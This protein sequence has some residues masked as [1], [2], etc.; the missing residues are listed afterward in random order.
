MADFVVE[1]AVGVA[2]EDLEKEELDSK[3]EEEA[4]EVEEDPEDLKEEKM[5]R[6]VLTQD[7]K[8]LL[9]YY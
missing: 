8:V 4:V 3:V 6:L 5:H 2:K 9:I 7:S 1:V